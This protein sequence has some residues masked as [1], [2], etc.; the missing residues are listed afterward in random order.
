MTGHSVAEDILRRV[1]GFY[2]DA[3]LFF[4]SHFSAIRAAN[5]RERAILENAAPFI[6]SDRREF[7]KPPVVAQRSGLR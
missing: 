4:K 6:R 2:R 7:W 5:C 1:I 3:R